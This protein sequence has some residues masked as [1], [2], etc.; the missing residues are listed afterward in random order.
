[1]SAS[2]S[3]AAEEAVPALGP[4]EG[5]PVDAG[6]IDLVRNRSHV[7]RLITWLGGLLFPFQTALCLRLTLHVASILGPTAAGA[8]STHASLHPLHLVSHARLRE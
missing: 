5:R 6:S 7:S 4:L 2:G 8:G 1:M 3:P